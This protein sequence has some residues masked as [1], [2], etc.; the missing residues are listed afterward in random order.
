[1]RLRRG[2]PV[3]KVS[4]LALQTGQGAGYREHMHTC[5]K[6]L[7]LFTCAARDAD[8]QTGTCGMC[9]L[10]IRAWR[11]ALIVAGILLI[12]IVVILILRR[13]Y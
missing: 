11:I 8:L 1:M 9:E 12:I 6:C 2:A 7:L 3:K 4:G 13:R 5:R 10:S